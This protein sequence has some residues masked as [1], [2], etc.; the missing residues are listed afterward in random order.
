[1]LGRS[2]SL[3]AVRGAAI[4]LVIGYH[5][6]PKV[7]IWGDEMGVTLFFVLSGYLIGGILLDTRESSRFFST[8]YARRAFRILPLYVVLIVFS[9]AST[10][11]VWW[12]VTF[13]QNIGWALTNSFPAGDPLSVTWSLAVEEQFYLLLPILIWLLPPRWLTRVL[14]CCVITAPLWRWAAFH[15]LGLVAAYVLLPC[16]LDALMGGALIACWQRGNGNAHWVLF[17]AVAPALDFGIHVLDP[18]F[19]IRDL[20]AFV[21]ALSIF[22]ICAIRLPQQKFILL[23]PLCWLGIG[24]YAVYLFHLP[25]LALSGQNKVVALLVSAGVAA[26]CWHFIESPLINIARRRWNYPDGRISL[27][28]IQ[29]AVVSQ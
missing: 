22:L 9:M 17:A 14:W 25:V 21:F 13:S 11:S 27:A 18:T 3:D 4:A 1:M 15:Y 2:D 12:F 19:V 10:T 26:I 8:F 23:R 20:S 28:Q 24:A 29:T 6:W 7:V 16:R 5:Y